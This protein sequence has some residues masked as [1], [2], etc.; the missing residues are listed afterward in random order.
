MKSITEQLATSFKGNPIANML[1]LDAIGGRV[2]EIVENEQEY[3]KEWPEN[4][5]IDVN[6]WIDTAKDI[7]ATMESISNNG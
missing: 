5:L 3:I 4:H 7:K 2:N 6:L 1:I